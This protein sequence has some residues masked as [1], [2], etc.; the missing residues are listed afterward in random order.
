LLP[1][2]PPALRELLVITDAVY[3]DAVL[4]HRL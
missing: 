1:A 2:L 4:T 3:G